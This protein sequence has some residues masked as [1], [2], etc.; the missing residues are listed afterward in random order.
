MAGEQV[1]SFT[2]SPLHEQ[3]DDLLKRCVV[4]YPFPALRS[5][6][7]VLS[8]GGQIASLRS[9]TLLMRMSKQIAVYMFNGAMI[10]LA[11]CVPKINMDC[12]IGKIGQMMQELV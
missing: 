5:A 6:K 7:P 1:H 12:G 4:A 3:G 10:V 8:P 2:G 9:S 11:R